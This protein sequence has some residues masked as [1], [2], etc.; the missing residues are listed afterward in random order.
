MRKILH[1]LTDENDCLASRTID[2]QKNM[3]NSG[4]YKDVEIEIIHLANTENY[5]SVIEKIFQADS[6]QVW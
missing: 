4:Q 6:V 2:F 3:V 1:L 5:E